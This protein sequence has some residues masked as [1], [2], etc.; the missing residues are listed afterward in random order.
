MGV[1]LDNPTMHQQGYAVCNLCFKLSSA[2]ASN[3]QYLSGSNGQA[4]NTRLPKGCF[5]RPLQ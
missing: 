4:S 5:N 2:S 1:I 3:V